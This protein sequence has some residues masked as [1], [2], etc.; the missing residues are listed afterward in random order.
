MAHCV[1]IPSRTD[2]EER[3]NEVQMVTSAIPILKLDDFGGHVELKSRWL[4]TAVFR[5]SQNKIGTSSSQVT[6]G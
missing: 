6:G 4:E 3:G 5:A 1:I 2:V